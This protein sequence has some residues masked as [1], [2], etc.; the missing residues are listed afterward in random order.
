M[1]WAWFLSTQCPPDTDV[2]PLALNGNSEL[3][4]LQI[5]VLHCPQLR[6]LHKLLEPWGHSKSFN[7]GNQPHPWAQKLYLRSARDPQDCSL[8]SHW[9]LRLP[10][11]HSITYTQMLGWIRPQSAGLLCS[12]AVGGGWALPGKFRRTPLLTTLK[13]SKFFAWH[14]KNPGK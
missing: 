6:T 11:Q 4:L 2:T 9:D 1:Y 12:L 7:G 10:H 8:D 14:W 5:L 13:R 3:I